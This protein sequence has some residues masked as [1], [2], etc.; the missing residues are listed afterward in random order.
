MVYTWGEQEHALKFVRVQPKGAPACYLCTT[1]AS[2]GLFIDTFKVT[3]K[4]DEAMGLLHAFEE[5]ARPKGPRTWVWRGRNTKTVVLAPEWMYKG[6][7]VPQPTAEHP[8]NYVSVGGALCFAS[9]LGCRLPTVS[10]WRA[11][12]D[13]YAGGRKLNLRDATWKRQLDAV[14]QQ[15]AA[16]PQLRPVWPDQ[17][18]F[19]PPGVEGQRGD[20]A[21]LVTHGSDDVLWLAPVGNGAVFRHLVGNVAEFVRTDD[22]DVHKEAEALSSWQR[23]DYPNLDNQRLDSFRVIGGSALSPPEL[24]DGKG[25]PFHTA[26]PV[27]QEALW[28]GYADVGFRLAFTAPRGTPAD[29]LKRILVEAGIPE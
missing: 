13:E 18:I 28:Q 5:T 26:Y 23:S 4:W 11:A 12:H 10:E 1:E 14:R 7:D 2:V 20:R 17:D 8:V 29:R 9:L 25:K 15:A 16:K 19:W 27:D 6:P 22:T 3:G 21:Q 24:W